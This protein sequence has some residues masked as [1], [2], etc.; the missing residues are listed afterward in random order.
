M[1]DIDNSNLE[2]LIGLYLLP[3]Q[4]N[5][6]GVIGEVTDIPNYFLTNEIER[7]LLIN[8]G[9]NIVASEAIIGSSVNN[10]LRSSN[11]SKICNIKVITSVEV[12]KL[13]CSIVPKV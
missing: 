9:S 2:L 13:I 12:L 6:V 4:N 11:L 3:L 7:K 10:I 5:S 1:R 8:A